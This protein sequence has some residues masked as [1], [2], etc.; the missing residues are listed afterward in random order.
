MTK[1]I[2]QLGLAMSV[3]FFVAAWAG[4]IITY[5]STDSIAAF[6]VA[7][8][9]AALA[10]EIL[11]WALAIIGGWTL[12]ANRRKLWDRLTGDAG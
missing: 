3:L 5:F 6:T 2:R 10:T 4:V 8:T 7:V 11:V 12:F 1:L 9:V